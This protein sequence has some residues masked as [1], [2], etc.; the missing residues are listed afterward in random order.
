MDKNRERR[1]IAVFYTWKEGR[2]CDEAEGTALQ[3]CSA[4]E[5]RR[6]FEVPFTELSYHSCG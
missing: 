3:P 2:C 1:Q 4:R 5:T 6:V